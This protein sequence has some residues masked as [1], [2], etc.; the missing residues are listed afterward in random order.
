MAIIKCFLLACT[1]Y[2]LT[3]CASDDRRPASYIDKEPRPMNYRT[4]N[5][6]TLF[7]AC[8]RER[9]ERSCRNRM[10]R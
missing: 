2:A 5:T 9:P 7:E 1:A 8:L 4:M 3:A 10:G 6:D